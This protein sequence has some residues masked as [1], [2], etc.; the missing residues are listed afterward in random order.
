LIGSR[1]VA[2]MGVRT[3]VMPVWGKYFG[4]QHRGAQPGQSEPEMATK[5]KIDALVNYLKYIQSK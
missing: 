5:T 3:R 4:E 1:A 2:L